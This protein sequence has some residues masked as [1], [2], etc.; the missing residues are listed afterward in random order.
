M[1]CGGG[2]VQ[3]FYPSAQKDEIHDEN[4]RADKGFCCYCNYF[5]KS[6]L[7]IKLTKAVFFST[8]LMALTLPYLWTSPLF[9]PI[10]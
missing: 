3:L 6:L 10:F 4:G 8:P 9:P 7:E 2:M 5:N 1:K